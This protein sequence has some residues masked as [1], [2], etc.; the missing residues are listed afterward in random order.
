MLCRARPQRELPTQFCRLESRVKKKTKAQPKNDPGPKNILCVF[1]RDGAASTDRPSWLL[2]L[3]VFVFVAAMSYCHTGDLDLFFHLKTGEWVSQHKAIP[4]LDPFSL[5]AAGQP[6][7]AHEWL[8]G[9]SLYLAHQACG[10]AGVIG[11]KTLLVTGLFVVTAMSARARGARAGAT[12]LVLA[13]SYAISRWR[14]TERP[15]TLSLLIAAAF[16]L[17]YEI[18][19]TRRAL[20]WL[21]PALQL[22]WANA[23]GGTA[24]LGWALAGIFLLDRA[25]ELGWPG[26]LGHFLGRR[27]LWAAWGAFLGVIAVSFANPNVWRALF[28]GLLR[29]ES[30]LKIREFQPLSSYGFGPN[31]VVYVFMGWAIVH[32]ALLLISPRKARVY[33][34]LLFPSMLL[35]GFS[36]FRFRS[37]FALLLAPSLAWQLSQ[38]QWAARV[39]AWIP[40]LAAALLLAR[41]AVTDA[42]AYGFRFGAGLRPELPVEASEFVKSSGMAGRMFN[43]YEHGGYLMWTL[44]PPFKVFIDGREDVYVKNGVLGEYLSCFNSRGNWQQI[45]AKYGIDFAVVNYPESPPASLEACIDRTAFDRA[46]WALVHFDD[47]AAVYVRR[48]GRNDE[49]V[50]RHEIKTVEPFQLS[51]YLDAIAGDPPRLALFLKETDDN[52]LRH[53]NSYR[54]HFVR[55]LLAVKRGPQFLAEAVREFQSTAAANPDYAP[56]YFNLG[57]VLSYLGRFSEARAAYER[58]LALGENRGAAEQ[59]E[60]LRSR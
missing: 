42:A 47:S 19:T 18:S 44:P 3:P 37:L 33:E 29:T 11:L 20:L 54:T 14:F 22:V 40:A 7:V 32:G 26:S 36:F 1:L 21:L 2:T 27:E 12:T 34:W 43:T 25:C 17:V 60:R 31:V 24:L 57:G 5:T 9:L 53:P 56:A 30:P 59:L 15:E 49:I 51:T 6:W 55:G 35:L 28:Y 41:V 8:S 13:A 45:V 16:V 46:E 23:H 58:V 50:R 48:N 10:L 4:H 39:R 38:G 52:L